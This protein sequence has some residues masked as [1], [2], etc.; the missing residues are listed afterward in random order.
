MNLSLFLFHIFFL[1]CSKFL[2]FYGGLLYLLYVWAVD[3]FVNLKNYTL[4]QT[5]FS[6]YTEVSDRVFLVL[7]T[8]KP[9]AKNLL[10]IVS[11]FS[12]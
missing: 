9:S 7:M 4:L 1:L 10:V 6:L 3:E 11:F 2:S 8:L 12:V 5:F